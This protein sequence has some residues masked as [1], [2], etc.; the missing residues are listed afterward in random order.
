M[1]AGFT[2]A[3]IDPGVPVP[4]AGAMLSQGSVSLAVKEVD[5]PVLVIDSVRDVGNLPP[6][7]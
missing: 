2:E 1:P 6:I 4:L 5:P 7:W 3:R